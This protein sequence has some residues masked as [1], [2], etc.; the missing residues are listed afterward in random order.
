MSW[1]AI[2]NLIS[3]GLFPIAA[4]VALAWFF[5][6]TNE[7]YRGDIKDLQKRHDSEINKLT[8]AV[9]NNTMVMQRL[10]DRLSKEDSKD[11]K[12]ELRVG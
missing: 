12:D 7:N 8:E 10:V 6:K 4:C 1:D 2:M 11:G 9:N 5:N 3:S